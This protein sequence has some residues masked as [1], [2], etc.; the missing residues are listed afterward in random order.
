MLG[1]EVTGG[2]DDVTG[3]TVTQLFL[4]QFSIAHLDEI[5]E[6]G[7]VP[8][9]LQ[10]IS[11]IGEEC[12]RRLMCT[13]CHVK[14]T[15]FQFERFTLVVDRDVF[16]VLNQSANTFTDLNRDAGRRLELF[17]F[18]DFFDSTLNA[19]I[20]FVASRHPKELV[21]P[22]DVIVQLILRCPRLIPTTC[23]VVR[24]LQRLLHAFW[25]ESLHH[26]RLAF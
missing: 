7:V 19:V 14:V 15:V 6:C 17:A 21:Q 3:Q 26:R 2:V 10:E 4:D 23:V 5:R 20:E 11:R 24:I 12:F 13:H 1:G 22:C 9:C 16:L 8:H 25:H 18:T